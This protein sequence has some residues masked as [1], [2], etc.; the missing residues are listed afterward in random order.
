MCDVLSQLWISTTEEFPAILT[1][2]LRLHPWP[3]GLELQLRFAATANIA[4]ELNSNV[5]ILKA[6]FID[7]CVL[8]K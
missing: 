6:F 1:L 8:N 5:N 3:V 2:M 7:I 4:N